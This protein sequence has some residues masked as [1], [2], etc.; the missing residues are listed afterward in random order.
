M[1]V[2]AGRLLRCVEST[3]WMPCRQTLER[4]FCVVADSRYALTD[5]WQTNG[6]EERSKGWTCSDSTFVRWSPAPPG[7]SCR[8][9]TAGAGK[10]KHPASGLPWVRDLV[11]GGTGMSKV[12]MVGSKST[13]HAIT[14]TRP[15]CAAAAPALPEPRQI[16]DPCVHQNRVLLQRIDRNPDVGQR[17]RRRCSTSSRN[18]SQPSNLLLPNPWPKQRTPHP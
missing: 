16:P 1:R 18:Q 10:M 8:M 4:Q 5:R 2:R 3:G 12:V 9:S 14:L 13:K 11:D 7:G 17:E 6:T 15:A